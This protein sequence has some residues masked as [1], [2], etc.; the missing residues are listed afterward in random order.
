VVAGM[1]KGKRMFW[2]L[3]AWFLLLLVTSF[4]GMMLMLKLPNIET[5]TLFIGILAVTIFY[6]LLAWAVYKEVKKQ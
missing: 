2:I 3:F 6:G 4:E 1:N 5:I